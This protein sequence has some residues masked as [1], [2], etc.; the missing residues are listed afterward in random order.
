MNHKYKT[1]FQISLKISSQP[2]IKFMMHIITYSV[3]I[4]MIIACRSVYIQ[5]VK[6]SQKFSDIF[7]NE[8]FEFKSYVNNHQ[9]V[10][11]HPNYTEDVYFRTDTILVI[12][13]I[14]LIW[15]F[16]FAW[17]EI[18]QINN[19][20]L[21]EYFHLEHNFLDLTMILLYMT[22]YFLKFLTI[23]FIRK[24]KEKLDSSEFKKKLTDAYLQD[25]KIQEEIFYTL[26]WLNAGKL[27]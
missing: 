16:G 2:L 9:L 23:W 3:F 6:K 24:E 20:G 15:V 10:H 5:D 14:I 11:N 7:P 26:N 25:V 22:C 18:K 19:Y 21:K 13:I 17:L 27:K 4:C 1:S 8:T 12:D